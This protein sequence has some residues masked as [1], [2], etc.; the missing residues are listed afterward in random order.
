MPATIVFIWSFTELG[1]PLVFDY[2][3]VTPVQIYTRLKEVETEKREPYALTL[4]MLTAAIAIY[5]L[6]RMVFGGRAYA[7]Y[8][9]A[10]RAGGERLADRHSGKWAVTGLFTLVTAAGSHC[11][12]QE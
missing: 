10:S 11:R 12:T 8:S 6:G 4:V 2:A 5:F 3:Q 9:K 7:M 1:T